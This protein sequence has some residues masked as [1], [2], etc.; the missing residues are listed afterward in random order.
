M[1]RS[2][3]TAP[4]PAPSRAFAVG[5]GRA[6]GGALLFGLPLLMTMEMW[7]LGLAMDRLRL[8]ILL[9]SALP[10]L[11]GLSYYGGFEETPSLREDV[12][13]ALIA[14]LVGTASSVVLLALFGALGPGRT[15]SEIVAMV[16]LQAAPASVGALLA[17]SQLGGGE[18]EKKDPPYFGELFLMAVGALFLSL[19]IA[20]TEETVLIAAKMTPVR[21]ILLALLSLAVMHAFVYVVEF[22][23]QHARPKG[24]G[25]AAVFLRF[26]L[27]GYALALLMSVYM[28]WLFG[29]L[30]GTAPTE[31]ALIAVVLGFPAAMGA[32]SARLIL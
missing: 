31:A 32:A 30:D 4:G 28:L 3:A 20:P 11:V 26:T 15:P 19:N 10:L 8:C 12:R 9:L 29:R 5:I 17:R 18:R 14:I 2:A 23:G 7:A 1:E 22:H 6:F 27:V 25:F 13:D 16:A 21:G 24:H